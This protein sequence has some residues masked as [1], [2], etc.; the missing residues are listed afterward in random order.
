MRRSFALGAVSAVFLLAFAAVPVAATT[1]LDVEFAVTTTGPEGGPTGGPF[2]ASGPAVDA[3]LVCP[4]GTTIDVGAKAAGFQSQA[5]V[6]LLV[7]K[8]FDC[9]DLSGSFIVKLQVRLD[10]RGDNFAWVVV[11]GDGAYARLRGAG[12]G[13]GIPFGTGP[14]VGVDDFY[15]GALHID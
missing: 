7:V 14:D 2:V 11:N 10:S 5:G 3:G 15:L 8:A 6:N 9:D 12:D 1:P 13:Y 4:T